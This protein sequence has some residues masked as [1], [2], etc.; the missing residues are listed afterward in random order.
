MPAVGVDDIDE[1]DGRQRQAWVEPGRRG[2]MKLITIPDRP[3]P[4][5]DSRRL[6]DRGDRVVRP[7]KPPEMT[8]QFSRQSAQRRVLDN[9]EEDIVLRVEQLPVTLNKCEA[10]AF[11]PRHLLALG[12]VDQEDQ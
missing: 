2:Q 7:Q 8:Q 12:V 5:Q 4:P 10:S 3:F 11:N 9:V 6:A 1:Q